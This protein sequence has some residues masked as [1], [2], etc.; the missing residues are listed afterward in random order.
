MSFLGKRIGFPGDFFIFLGK[1]LKNLGKISSFPGKNCEKMGEDKL[2]G[3][4][5]F[6]L[7]A[8]ILLSKRFILMRQLIP[9]LSIHPGTRH[10][11]GNCHYNHGKTGTELRKQRPGAGAR[12]R[13]AQ[14]K[15]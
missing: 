10:C 6:H 4:R 14:T 7:I 5:L 9:Q 12:H 11:T 15:Y 13:P 8:A 2:A 1:N 3:P